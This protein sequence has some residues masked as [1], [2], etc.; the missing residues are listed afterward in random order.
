M[1]KIVKKE[2]VIISKHLLIAI[3][4]PIMSIIVAGLDKATAYSMF[5]FSTMYFSNSTIYYSIKDDKKANSHM[6]FN[7][8]PIDRSESIKS[9]YIVYS[10]IPIF[11]G[12]V[13]YLSVLGSQN[14]DHP[15]LFMA[16]LPRLGLD[17]LIIS[18]AFSLIILALSI[19]LLYKKDKGVTAIAVVISALYLLG[20][21]LGGDIVPS[22]LF[23]QFTWIILLGI[24]IVVYLMSLKVLM[25]MEVGE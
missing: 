5:I 8:F 22:I 23:N 4:L 7:S 2:I 14:L 6:L 15:I 3:V 21:R 17:L 18:I 10:M 11:Y 12:I 16:E 25:K 24:S 9:K 1:K 19:P 20:I 13:F